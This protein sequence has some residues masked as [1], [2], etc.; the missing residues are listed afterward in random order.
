MKV[1]I[2]LTAPNA[3]LG[4]I[5]VA[6]EVITTAPRVLIRWRGR[7]GEAECRVEFKRQRGIPLGVAQL[8]HIRLRD[9]TGDC[10]NGVKPFEPVDNSVDCSSSGL[11]N[12]QVERDW[13]CRPTI[14]P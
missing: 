5:A 14:R 2:V 13:K 6:A 7:K 10:R 11:R 12:C 4:A 8:E 1:L 3:A 9:S